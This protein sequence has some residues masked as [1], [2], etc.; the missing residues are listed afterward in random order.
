MHICA[1]MCQ[2]CRGAASEMQPAK[3]CFYPQ[4]LSLSAAAP[5]Q[6]GLN[7]GPTPSQGRW[8]SPCQQIMKINPF[9]SVFIMLL[10][11]YLPLILLI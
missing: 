5:W 6:S 4:T 2:F 10:Y 9:T 7:C 3:R 11:R 8:W 1:I